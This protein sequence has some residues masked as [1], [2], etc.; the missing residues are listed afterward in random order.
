MIHS[1]GRDRPHRADL[2]RRFPSGSHTLTAPSGVLASFP[3]V[4]SRADRRRD[5]A[6]C[7]APRRHPASIPA[8]IICD[9]KTKPLH[10]ALLRATK[11][12]TLGATCG[13]I[14]LCRCRRCGGASHAPGAQ[15][16]GKSAT[17]IPASSCQGYRR[18][19]SVTPVTRTGELRRTCGCRELDP[20]WWRS[21]LRSSRRRSLVSIVESA[22]LGERDHPAQFRSLG[23]PRGRSV[24]IQR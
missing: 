3:R 5:R 15:R 21:R 20:S 8:S 24:A 18:T 11:R 7:V 13:P 16:A 10:V 4:T 14:P 17:G 19:R 9:A 1:R 22:H 12:S 2:N 23:N 6:S